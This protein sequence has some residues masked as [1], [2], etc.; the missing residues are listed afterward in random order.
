MPGINTLQEEDVGSLISVT[1]VGELEQSSLANIMVVVGG[2]VWVRNIPGPTGF[3]FCYLHT[4]W[5]ISLSDGT[6]HIQG[7]PSQLS[8]APLKKPTHNSWN[9]LNS[10]HAFQSIQNDSQDYVSNKLSWVK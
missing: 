1:T 3:L 10:S 4:I 5:D 8:H 7:M 9:A 2:R 6:F